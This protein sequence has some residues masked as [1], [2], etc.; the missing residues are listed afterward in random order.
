MAKLQSNTRIYG[1]ANIDST[2]IVGQIVST[3]S[4]STNTGTIQIIGGVGVSGNV[5]AANVYTNGLF[6]AANGLPISTGG[7]GSAASGYSNNM[8]LVANT[9]GFVSNTSNLF[10][11]AAN[12]TL[13]SSNVT[14]GRIVANTINEITSA[15]AIA[16]GVL[17]LNLN[18]GPVFNVA[19]NANITTMT[20]TNVSSANTVSSFI[21]I[22]TAD[23]TLRSVS[24]PTTF[25]W[26]NGINPAITPTL[27]KRDV[28][29]FF[30]IDGGLRWNAF[31]TGQAL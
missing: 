11:Y 1:T 27:N 15:P 4:V 3:S 20:L 10:Y 16:A 23:G 26:P 13:V 22:F 19:L 14:V 12:N 25:S 30:T 31:I 24:W 2:L 7:G 9:S 5:Y 28:Y 17:T 21:L 8:V 29:T 6:Y 18:N